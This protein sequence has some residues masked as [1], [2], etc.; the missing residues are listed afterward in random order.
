[1]SEVFVKSV[2]LV[3][4]ELFVAILVTSGNMVSPTPPN[5]QLYL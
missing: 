1:M 3:D 4:R 5:L 2:S